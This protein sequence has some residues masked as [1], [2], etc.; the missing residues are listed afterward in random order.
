[1]AQVFASQSPWFAGSILGSGGNEN[2][3]V[4]K[5][6]RRINYSEFKLIS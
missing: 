3:C 2:A 4:Y 1:M 5:D 6:L